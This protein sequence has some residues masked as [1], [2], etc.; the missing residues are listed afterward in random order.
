MAFLRRD[1]RLTNQPSQ[2]KWHTSTVSSS[3]NNHC[4]A[5]GDTSVAAA[6]AAVAAAAAAAAVV[7]VVVDVEKCGDSTG[8]EDAAPRPAAV[9]P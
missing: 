6:A 5:V 3:N 1:T 7:P 4:R 8:E 9:E 2:P